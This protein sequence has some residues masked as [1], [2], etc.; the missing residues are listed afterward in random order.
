MHD[1]RKYCR[2]HKNHRHYTEDCRDLKEQKE[3][4]IWKGKLQKYV[5]RG[6]SSRYRGGKKDQHE[7]SQKDKDNMPPR[8]QS[9][10][11]EIKT[12]T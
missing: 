9:A 2:F 10:I 6:D 5:K 8:S 3:E 4:L 12:I 11:R 7:G 1:K